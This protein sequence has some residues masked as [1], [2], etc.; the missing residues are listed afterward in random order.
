MQTHLDQ[1]AQRPHPL[2][3]PAALLAAACTL[4]FGGSARAQGQAVPLFLQSSELYVKISTQWGGAITEFTPTGGQNLVDNGAPD[5]G[6]SIQTAFRRQD[7]PPIPDCWPCRTNPPC[8]HVW[9]PTQAG[10]CANVGSGVISIEGNSEYLTTY[11]QLRNF[12]ADSPSFP[13]VSNVYLRQTLSFARANVLKLEYT[14]TNNETFAFEDAQEF[15]VAFLKPFLN[16]A[17]RYTGSQPFT[18]DWVEIVDVPCCTENLLDHFTTTEPWIAWVPDYEIVPTLTE[19]G[20]GLYVPTGQPHLHWR[21]HRVVPQGSTAT[22]VMQNFAYFRLEP[23]ESQSVTVYLIYGNVAEIR[24]FVYEHEAEGGAN[25]NFTLTANPLPGGGNLVDL[26]WQGHGEEV[27]EF[28]VKR[29]RAAEPGWSER[30]TL[31]ASERSYRD[32]VDVVP[33]EGSGETAYYF[34][35]VVALYEGTASE[36]NRAEARMYGD[37][38][39]RPDTLRPRGC[40]EGNDPLLTWRGGGRS[41]SFYTHLVNTASGEEWDWYPRVNSSPVPESLVPGNIYMLKVIGLNNVGS[42]ATSGTGYFAS[43]CTALSAPQIE[44]PPPG[45][46]ATTTPLLDWTPVTDI[47]GY[48]LRLYEWGPGQ[49]EVCTGGVGLDA[50][51]TSWQVPASAPGCP[52]LPLKAGQEYWYW[53]KANSAEDGPYSHIRFFVPQ[54]TPSTLGTPSPL[55]PAGG[56]T[57]S[58]FPAYSWDVAAQAESYTLE[59]RRLPGLELAGQRTYTAAAICDATTCR[60]QPLDL[61]LID[62]SY[63]FSVRAHKAGH[64]DTGGWPYSDFNV[65]R[66][67]FTLSVADIA[68]S[69]GT[70]NPT[71]ARFTIRL[72][73]RAASAITVA[74]ATANGTA[75]AGGDYQA[76]AG[77]ATFALGREEAVVDVPLVADTTYELDQTFLLNLANA[78]GATIVDGQA[79]AT[80]RNDD[81][82]PTLTA[83]GVAVTELDKAGATSTAVFSVSLSNPTEL[84]ASVTYATADC[85]ATAGTDYTATSGS[86][87]FPA[88]GPLAQ[89]VSVVVQGDVLPEADETFLLALGTPT[90]AVLATGLAPGVI[91]DNDRTWAVVPRAD[92]SSPLDG[93]TDLLFRHDTGGNLVAWYLDGLFRLGG[94]VLDPP[95][96]TTG[97]WRI[98]GEADFGGDGKADLLWQN[99]DSGNLSLWTM[100]G[101]H[102]TAGVS[103][104]GPGSP[105]TE[106]VATADFDRNGKVDLLF[107]D[108]ASGALTVW[109]MDGPTK[110]SEAN[111]TPPTDLGWTIAAVGDLDA[112]GKVDL[113]W[114]HAVTGAL[115]VWWMDGVTVLSGQPLSPA[116]LDLAWQAV[117][118]WDVDADGKNDILWQHQT[119]KRLV[120]WLMNGATRICGSYLEP[121]GPAL[122]VY[123]AV[124]PR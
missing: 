79:V 71:A 94:A 75:L 89:T 56:T 68:V 109:F 6:R 17:V 98:V 120:A 46:I 22:N 5:P 57:E 58:A 37:P 121:A 14:V 100:D 124:G 74:F 45:C 113:L 118:I 111:I 107:R 95:Q 81:P 18:G 34:Y 96:P 50:A 90:G 102:R 103:F 53:V 15:P 99:A 64:A 35:K 32:E 25:G 82:T 93:K 19:K 48:H 117:G 36:S 101:I 41:T 23:G 110:L 66:P 72:N 1:P 51:T 39:G 49:L 97:D 31:P 8:N 44:S 47:T 62:G 9:N 60:A 85:T 2:L 73:Q 123:S 40:L 83:T 106:V 69:E 86:L 38:P 4:L 20:L 84:G 12:E 116:S 114:R 16:R 59:V 108:T 26:S 115:S 70:T 3:L 43:G 33:E 11:A 65:V 91:R 105:A 21:F 87:T 13:P 54:C 42:G 76:V 10:S 52:R 77:T 28:I 29:R 27:D 61:P 7:P 67:P 104:A 63:R 55:A 80:I 78:E 88:N 122:P 24:D 92:F 112:N 30:A 119:S